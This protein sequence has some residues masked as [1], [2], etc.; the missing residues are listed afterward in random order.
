MADETL[1]QLAQLLVQGMVSAIF[2][3]A[4]AQ[5]RKE[6]QELLQQHAKER[7]VWMKELIDLA[8]EAYG[9]KA[10]ATVVQPVIPENHK[11]Q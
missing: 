4:W 6:R 1:Q 7:D 10:R 3:W 8:R 9:L 11:P 2:I 5:E